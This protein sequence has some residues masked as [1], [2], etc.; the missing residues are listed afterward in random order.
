MATTQTTTTRNPYAPNN[1]R[2]RFKSI[3]S[4]MLRK[5]EDPQF[6][7]YVMD[8]EGYD[9]ALVDQELANIQ[10][11]QQGTPMQQ[12]KPTF[13]AE[14]LGTGEIRKKYQSLLETQK[15]LKNYKSLLDEYTGKSGIN[16]TG[17]DAA[18]LR[19]AYSSLLFTIATA[20]GTGALQK[21]DRDVVEQGL[22]NPTDF[23][24]SLGNVARGG[25]SGQLAALNTYQNLIND[26]ISLLTGQSQAEVTGQPSAQTKQVRVQDPTQVQ[27]WLDANPNDP[28]AGK[29]RELLADQKQSSSVTQNQKEEERPGV[30]AAIGETFSDLGGRISNIFKEV[31]K[32]DEST[33]DVIANILGEKQLRVLGE[34]AGGVGDV[35]EG[36]TKVAYRSLPDRVQSEI[37]SGFKEL[38]DTEAGRAGIA[39]LGEGIEAYNAWAKENPNAAKDIEAVAN[40]VS[41]VPM[42]KAGSVVKKEAT[43]VVSDVMQLKQGLAPADDVLKAQ[44]DAGLRPNVDISS[45]SRGA[46][47]SAETAIKQGFEERDVKFLIS[48]TPED[49]KIAGD[50]L[51]LAEEANKDPRVLVRPIDLA[52]KTLTDKLSIVTNKLKEYGKEVDEAAKSLRGVQVDASD[53]KQTA[54]QAFEQLGIRQTEKGLS[55]SDS[56]F[57]MTPSIQKIIKNFFKEIPENTSDAYQLHIFKKSIDELVNYGVQGEGIEGNAERLL[58]EL[59][60]KADDI[61]D[62]SF[63]GY[64]IANEKFREAKEIET[65]ARDLFGKKNP[66]DSSVRGGQVLRSA[67]SNNQSRAKVYQLAEMLDNYQKQIEGKIT[68]NSL[69]QALFAEILEKSGLFKTQAITGFSGSIE[70]AIKKAGGIANAVRNPISA[71]LDLAAKGIEKLQNVSP[72]MKKKALEDLLNGILKEKT[73]PELKSRLFNIRPGMSIQDVNIGRPGHSLHPDDSNSLIK[74]IDAVRLKT[75]LSEADWTDAER[76]LEKAGVSLDQP[77]SRLASVAEEIV[78]GKKKLVTVLPGTRKN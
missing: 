9:M 57:K 72:E 11:F 33:R 28:R 43:A 59:R 65:L 46:K 52:G 70:T 67:F 63:D 71:G 61:L 10:S 15:E 17:E 49:R 64:R 22:P 1:E 69:D 35:F 41:V 23:L 27:A 29:I 47:K 48:M 45:L 6:I 60:S 34:V 58:K 76:L 53:L 30:I 16:L 36:L 62:N 68:G 54:L 42:L 21:S 26:K 50:M 39:A 19:A 5:K 75:K 56:V 20:Q 12:A 24:A 8:Q 32:K 13:D 2:A 37:E 73:I 14:S 4:E 3:L 44:V 77:L 51:R 40:I 7:R 74:F 25:K 55:F 66:L 78:S 31:K 38:L 18:K